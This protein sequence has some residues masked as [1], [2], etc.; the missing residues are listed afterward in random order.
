MD[1]NKVL[2]PDETSNVIRQC[3]CFK[4]LPV[5]PY[6]QSFAN[7]DIDSLSVWNIAVWQVMLL[8]LYNRWSSLDQ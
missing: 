2:S 7:Q 5:K 3:Q 1:T 6:T 8:A 4:G